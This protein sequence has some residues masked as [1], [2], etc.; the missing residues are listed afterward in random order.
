MLGGLL[1]TMVHQMSCRRDR[2]ASFGCC[3]FKEV[4]VGWRPQQG[5]AA[6][7][8][9]RWSPRMGRSVGQGVDV[10]TFASSSKTPH[11]H[12]HKQPPW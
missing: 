1:A 9:C 2:P 10:D 12:V 11:V 5:V 7:V 8:M 4:S 6:G 3:R